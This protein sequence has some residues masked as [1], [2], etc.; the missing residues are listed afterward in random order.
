MSAELYGMPAMLSREERRY[1]TWLTEHCFEGFGAIVDLGCWLGGSSCALAEGLARAGKPHRIHSY[2]LFVWEPGY[3]EQDAPLGRPQGWDFLPEFERRTAKYRQWLAPKKVDLTTFT[4]T[5]G[6]IEILFVDAAKTW[7]LLNS[8]LA[9]FGPALV[10]GRSRVV[11]QDYRYFP[12]HWLVPVIESR[13]DVWRE[14]E[15]VAEGYT[16]TFVP[17]RDL[18]GPGGLPARYG[19]DSFRFAGVEHI[20]RRRIEHEHATSRDDLLRVLMCWAL[21]DGTVAE[22]E[23][24]AGELFAGRTAPLSADERTW[25]LDPAKICLEAGW[26]ALSAGEHGL[27]DH[28]AQR[29]LAERP[30]HLPALLLALQV[31]SAAHGLESIAPL[32]T[33]IEGVAPRDPRVLLWGLT[34]RHARSQFAGIVEQIQAMLAAGLDEALRPWAIGVLCNC[35]R[36]RGDLAV[37]VATLRS[38]VPAHGNVAV[39]QAR[40]AEALSMAGERDQARAHLAR[41][42]ELEPTNQVAIEVQALLQRGGAAG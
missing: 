40:L 12:C 7:G 37:A 26:R 22:R 39:L 17:L 32:L 8:I 3:M 20:V 27:A 36:G 14:A 18:H 19:V 6:P 11:F 5:G 16:V 25:L 38:L 28:F 10:P 33:R 29:L 13:P 35:L 30:D 34:L 2:D 4:W 42:F 41:A 31:Q 24:I 23:R 21:L 9:A 1:L 15:A